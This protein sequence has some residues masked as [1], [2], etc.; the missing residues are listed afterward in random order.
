[1]GMHMSHKIILAVTAILSLT[2]CTSGTTTD[3][4]ND[5]ENNVPD[6]TELAPLNGEFLEYLRGDGTGPLYYTQTKKNDLPEGK[7]IRY[8][9]VAL[10]SPQYD[11]TTPG[12]QQ[13]AFTGNAEIMLDFTNTDGALSGKIKNLREEMVKPGVELP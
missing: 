10:I 7:A 12:E 4:I 13:V 6:T 5:K 9:G 2:A 1:M 11:A 8:Q 3:E